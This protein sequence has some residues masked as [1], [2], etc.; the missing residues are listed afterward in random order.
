VD[1][2]ITFPVTI[3]GTGT[4]NSS[5]FVVPSNVFSQECVF[6]VADK[7]NTEDFVTSEPVPIIPGLSI[8][9]G[10]GVEA[11]DIVYQHKPV[12]IVLD[13]DAG[14]LGVN[15]VQDWQV[16]TS[17]DPKNFNNATVNQVTGIDL[18]SGTLT[19]IPAQRDVKV[20]YQVST[21]N[22]KTNNYPFELSVVSEFPIDIE[23]ATPDCP[24]GTGFDICNVI[25]F[26]TAPGKS[27]NFVP[28][29]EVTLQ[30]NYVGT[31]DGQA[32]WTYNT[33][34]GNVIITPI[35]GPG[36][37]E[38]GTVTY[39]WIIT[40]NSIFTDTFVLSVLSSSVSKSSR[41]Y[42]VKPSF[43]WTSPKGGDTLTV[44]PHGTTTHN[45]YT[46]TMNFTSD[47]ASEF[48]S[49]TPGVVKSDGTESMFFDNRIYRVDHVSHSQTV[50]IW[51]LDAVDLS[52]VPGKKVEFLVQF[53]AEN[54]DKSRILIKKTADTVQ[55]TGVNFNPVMSPQVMGTTT[56]SAG[57]DTST[58]NLISSCSGDNLNWYFV[59]LNKTGADSQPKG[60]VCSFDPKNP[61]NPLPICWNSPQTPQTE[62][63]ALVFPGIQETGE[64]QVQRI[65]NNLYLVFINSGIGCPA[66]TPTQGSIFD[67]DQ[68]TGCA[69][70]NNYFMWTADVM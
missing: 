45:F 29:D 6:K 49:W 60:N 70:A 67:T 57:I 15:S 36:T 5:S 42:T 66:W 24:G 3:P 8:T 14:L 22:L 28:G 21:L 27:N 9:K 64:F 54:A 20:Y 2:G 1:R 48:T 39:T 19:W 12:A 30:F 13:L 16:R 35:S 7:D 4:G 61:N 63:K 34:D 32:N 47:E 52:L 50:V 58:N 37:K 18:L 62:W 31:F 40:P 43:T 44:F 33:G 56:C 41:A 11:N 51:F 59:P 53:K 38:A 10:A 69:H 17:T 25:M 23:T 46:T 26:I 65:G 68:A 55:I